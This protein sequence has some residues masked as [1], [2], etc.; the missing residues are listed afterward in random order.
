M[1]RSTSLAALALLAL[2]LRGP[3]ATAEVSAVAPAGEPPRGLSAAIADAVVNGVDRG[4]FDFYVDEAMVPRLPSAVVR[5]LLD[6]VAKPE[7]VAAV[8]GRERLVRPDELRA[9]GIL[10]AFDPNALVLRF[11]V[12]P[13]ALAPVDLAAKAASPVPAAAGNEIKPES[14]AAILGLSLSLDPILYDEQEGPRSDLSASLRLKPS[15]DLF[16]FVAE[17]EASLSWADGFSSRLEGARLIRDFPE[18]GARLAGGLLSTRPVSFQ[19]DAE[20]LGLSLYREPLLPGGQRRSRSVGE[21]SLERNAELAIS[22]NGIEARRLHL[23]PG[24]YRLSDLPLSTGLNEVMVTIKEEGKAPRTVRMGLPFDAGILE[25]GALDYSLTLGM[26][27]STLARPLGAASISAGLGTGLEVGADLEAGLGEILGGASFLAASRLGNLGAAAALSLPYEGPGSAGFAA[28]LS[29]RFSALAERYLPRLG[30]AAEYRGPGFTPPAADPAQ[31][32]KADAATWRLSAQ[33]SESL[34]GG[35]GS[36]G[37]F[38]NASLADRSLESLALSAGL[39]LP[40]RG[41]VSLSLTGGY[42]WRSDKGGQPLASISVSVAPPDRRILQY[43]SDLVSRSDSFDLSMPLG[44]SSGSSLGLQGE[45]LLAPAG[46]RRAA[47]L[48]QA[49]AGPLD[50]GATGYWR[51]AADSAPAAVGASLGAST[52]LALAGGRLAAASAFGDAFAILAPH[53]S[54]GGAAVELRPGRGPA[55][56][57]LGGKPALVAGIKPYEDFVASIET[58]SS[59]PE[60]MP[61]PRTVRIK[62]SY[63]SVSIIEVWAASSISARGRLVDAAGKPKPYLAGEI[64]DPRGFPSG[65]APT[66]TDGDGSFECY[67]LDAGAVQVR[68]SDGSLSHFAVAK[69]KAPGAA[70]MLDLGDIAASGGAAGQGR[71]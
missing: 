5:E 6:G 23:G 13:R 40:L 37:A 7:L 39:F 63:H 21:I 4:T 49:A 41:S 52:S 36:F 67:G 31:V 66:F 2:A 12:Q 27:R 48:A 70:A 55:A 3:A 14:V 28:R 17:G 69:P 33:L 1:R 43:R 47:L 26:D 34:P 62:P 19:S 71:R 22:V 25:A 44:S 68:W 35:A 10:L 64:L 9:L 32:A 11:E 50:L 54:L 15:V 38:G 30:L 20:L 42:D 8:A 18:T 24:N 59:P 29:W 45:G 46:A 60:I 56:T 58:P 16:G 61:E 51:A 57:S 53:P 65:A